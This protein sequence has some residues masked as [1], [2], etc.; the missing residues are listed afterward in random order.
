[1]WHSHLN[2]WKFLKQKVLFPEGLNWVQHWVS[3]IGLLGSLS[4]YD[5]DDNNNVKKQFTGFMSKT[6]ALHVCHA[7]WYISS[8]STARL[9]RET[10]QRDVLWRTYAWTHFKKFSLLYLN[11]DKALE[12]WTP[13]KVTHIW[14]IERFQIDVIKFKRRKFVFFFLWCFHCRRRRRCLRSLLPAVVS[15]VRAESEGKKEKGAQRGHSR[16]VPC[17]AASLRML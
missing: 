16:K 9:R 2:V 12:N 14:R 17:V 4:N 11:M 1:M 3:R 6:T 15:V 10:S 8:T 5:D 13:G 7:F